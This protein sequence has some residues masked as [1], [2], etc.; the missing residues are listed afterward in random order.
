MCLHG[1]YITL[2]SAAFGQARAKTRMLL[3]RG[4][5]RDLALILLRLSEAKILLRLSVLLPMDGRWTLYS[6][7]KAAGRL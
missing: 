1:W 5:A 2:M 6:Y 7:P 4:I 3:V